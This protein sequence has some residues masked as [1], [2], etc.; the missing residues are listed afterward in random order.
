MSAAVELRDVRR[1]FGNVRAVD[2][3]SL[4]VRAGEF[5]TLLGPSGCGKTTLVRLIA[6]F[7]A[8]DSGA[9]FIDG[10]DVTGVPSYRRDVN[11]VF[12]SYALFPHLTVSD[13]VAFG[14]RMQRKAPKEIV[15]R[16]GE[17]LALV[18]LEGCEDRKP[19]QL[20]G[21]QQQRVALA[22]ALAPQPA[23]LLLDEPLSALDARLRQAMQLELK[24][25]QRQ[26]GTTFIF[27]THDQEEALTMSDRIA[28]LRGGRVEQCGDVQEMYHRP[29]TAFAAEFVGQTNLLE[30]DLIARHGDSIRCRVSGG[31][32]LRLSAARW[33][34]GAS[35]AMV[36]IRPEKIHLSN[37]AREGGNSFKGVVREEFFKGATR[38][39]VIETEGG[40]TLNAL[41]ANAG[42]QCEIHVGARVCCEIHSD[43]IVVVP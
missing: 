23:V 14:L 25:L 8:P 18:A 5:L 28:L 31:L 40:M 33:P 35:R 17:V 9:V 20:S 2:G 11:Q 39:F 42:A 37:A 43:D 1:H 36:S 21:G 38:R 16:V 4:D 10:K 19:H 24:R 3:V 29:A 22:R 32:E 13:N 7:D 12:Q 30:A 27:V 26:V 41:A 15:Q 34:S 6:G